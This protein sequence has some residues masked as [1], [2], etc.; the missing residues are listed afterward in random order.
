MSDL[1]RDFIDQK[2][3][4]IINGLGGTIT[5][6]PVNAELYRD[7]LDRKFDD[8]INAIGN[9][10]VKSFTYI[11]D[12]NNINTIQFPDIPKYILSIQRKYTGNAHY[13]AMMYDLIWN[14]TQQSPAV[15][16]A[17]NG[18][19]VVWV[20]D[21]ISYSDNEMTITNFSSTSA[22]QILNTLNVEY[23]VYYI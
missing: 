5:P 9:V 6:P 12:G 18:S 13:M 20:L 4:Q 10:K 14:Y 21:N 22:G 3:D 1:Y 17:T 19:S 11:G 2:A 16:K 8:I 15:Y 23:T 7:F